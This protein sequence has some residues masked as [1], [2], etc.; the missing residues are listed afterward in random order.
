MKFL[1]AICLLCSPAF[2]LD[3]VL[4]PVSEFKPLEPMIAKATTYCGPDCNC[5]DCRCGQFHT[6][7]CVYQRF[8]RDANGS[9]VLS[10]GQS[11]ATN[12]RLAGEA[13]RAGKW[14]AV[15][16]QGYG[17]SPTLPAG[18]PHGVW[19]MDHNGQ[20]VRIGESYYRSVATG[21]QTQFANTF[22]AAGFF[23]QGSITGYRQ[24]CSGGTCRL[25][26]TYGW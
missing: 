22:P 2:A 15:A 6:L 8:L 17:K 11:D 26:P 20:T 23:G 16:N 13:Q 25:V 21:G 24:D 18:V 12:W 10:V 14:F 9:M 1:I 7:Q 19:Y 4:M 5:D 3:H